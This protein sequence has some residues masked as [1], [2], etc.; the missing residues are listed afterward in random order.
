MRYIRTCQLIDFLTRRIYWMMNSA[1][2][3]LHWQFF[4]YY[5]NPAGSYFGSKV[6]VRPEHISFSYDNG[7]V[8][9]INRLNSLTKRESA[10]RWVTI[11]LIDTAGKSLYHQRLRLQT[12]PNHSQEIANIAHAIGKI[13]DVGFLRLV[14][15]SDSKNDEVLSRNVY[16]LASQNDVLDWNNSNWFY[17]PISTYANYSALQNL[18]GANVV[19]T[20]NRNSSSESTTT[21]QVH[22]ENKSDDV[23]AFFIRLVLIDSKTNDSIDPPFWSDNYVTLFPRESLDLTVAFNSSL[24]STPAVEVSGGNIKQCVVTV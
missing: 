2:P 4:D 12:K 23:P 9:L 15:S 11:D 13:K 7:T 1:W 10:S 8:Y 5:L 18:H 16:W 6:G 20:V 17:T 3:N 24:S 21:L 19:T 22:L 14:L